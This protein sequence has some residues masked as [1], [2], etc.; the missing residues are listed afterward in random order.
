MRLP[1]NLSRSGVTSGV[2]TKIA[3]AGFS[4]STDGIGSSASFNNPWGVAVAADGSVF[5]AD[6]S[7]NSIRK[8]TAAGVV[9]TF[10]GAIANGLGVTGSADGI[11][12]AASFNKPIGIAVDSSGNVYVA[13][14]GNNTIRVINQSGVVSTFVGSAKSIG[15][16][17]GPLPASL[18]SPTS[19]TIFGSSLYITVYNAVLRVGL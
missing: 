16:L 13:D 15:N 4:G 17:P 7:N 2:V 19:V 6:T 9:S 10:A 1:P 3:G 5:V 18:A 8:I 12:A 14:S 11:G